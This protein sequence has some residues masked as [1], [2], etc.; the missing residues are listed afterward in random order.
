MP[1]QIFGATEFAGVENTGVENAGGNRKDGKSRSTK[2]EMPNCIESPAAFVYC[3][4]VL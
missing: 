4:T 3:S 1:W 2:Y